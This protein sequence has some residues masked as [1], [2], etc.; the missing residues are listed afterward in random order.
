M[1]WSGIDATMGSELTSWIEMHGAPEAMH[2]E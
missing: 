1:L 2:A